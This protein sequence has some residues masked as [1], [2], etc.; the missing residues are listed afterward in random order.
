V[1]EYKHE[2]ILGPVCTVAISDCIAFLLHRMEEQ[3][4]A[5]EEAEEKE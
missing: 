5:V 1:L 4:E 2:F 3:G